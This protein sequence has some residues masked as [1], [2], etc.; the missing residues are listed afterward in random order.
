MSD[1]NGESPTV[2]GADANFKGELSFD[3]SVRIEG[4][5]EGHIHSKGTLHIAEGA[6]VMANVEA[7]N[8]KIEGTCKG[9][10]TVSEK[11]HMLASAKVEGD[12][13][14]SR[15]EISDGAIFVGNVVVGQSAG[16]SS[17]SSSSSSSFRPTSVSQPTPLPIPRE[18]GRVDDGSPRP[19]V[20]DSRIPASS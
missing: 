5:F 20:Q 16:T 14:T 4:N 12:L 15:L 18:P 9:N 19:K 11:L 2:I 6:N 3:K 1:M 13:R 17:S 7:T 8:V 10:L